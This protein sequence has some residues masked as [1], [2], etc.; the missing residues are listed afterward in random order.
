MTG[1][2]IGHD[3]EEQI[4]QQVADIWREVLPFSGSQPDA[5]FFE[6]SG[7]SVA[8]VRIVSRIEEDLDVLIDVGDIFEDDPTLSSLTDSVLQRTTSPA[9][10]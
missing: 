10:G 8:A 1:Q 6:L 4:R 9:H 7:D 5:T 3:R 2:S